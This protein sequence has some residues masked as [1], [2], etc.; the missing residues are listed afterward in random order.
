MPLRPRW[1]THSSPTLHEKA[2][3]KQFRDNP[4][5]IYKRDESGKQLRPWWHAWTPWGRTFSIQWAGTPTA[6]Y[7]QY[8]KDLKDNNNVKRNQP[9]PAHIKALTHDE[10]CE[11]YYMIMSNFMSLVHQWYKVTLADTISLEIFA[12]HIDDEV[13]ER[14][15]H[16]MSPDHPDTALV[17]KTKIM[18]RARNRLLWVNTKHAWAWRDMITKR[19]NVRN[20]K[21]DFSIN[22]FTKEEIIN[23]TKWV[24]VSWIE[25]KSEIHEDLNI[26]LDL[27]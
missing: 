2:M 18:S 19:S 8:I 14:L 9:I 3:W 22:S 21:I 26:N 10:Y 16:I 6:L 1:K 27:L 13:K 15:S 17:Y 7:K 11:M 5:L 24:D 4:N 25:I 23:A 20:K 12:T